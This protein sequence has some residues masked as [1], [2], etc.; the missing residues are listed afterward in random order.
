MIKWWFGSR[1]WPDFFYLSPFSLELSETIFICQT[2]YSWHDDCSWASLFIVRRKTA[3]SRLCLNAFSCVHFHF[4]S[5]S[6]R[7]SQMSKKKKKKLVLRILWFCSVISVTRLFKASPVSWCV[8]PPT[9]SYD[10]ARCCAGTFLCDICFTHTQS[11]WQNEKSLTPGT[12]GCS[13]VC[14]NTAVPNSLRAIETFFQRPLF[15]KIVKIAC[16]LFLKKLFSLSKHISE[17]LKI[18]NRKC[19]SQIPVYVHHL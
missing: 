19:L 11:R 8:L 18:Q 14:G 12:E 1:L 7:T 2:Y 16:I 13:Q 5:L 15:C 6:S 9:S 3:T 4:F 10:L 17:L